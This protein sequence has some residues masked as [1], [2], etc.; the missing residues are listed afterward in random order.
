MW[1]WKLCFYSW[2][3]G[4]S[5]IIVNDVNICVNKVFLC[6]QKNHFDIGKWTGQTLLT[7]QKQHMENAWKEHK[8]PVI[9]D[10]KCHFMDGVL[11]KVDNQKPMWFT[12]IRDPVTRFQSMFHLKR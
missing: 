1:I 12:I 10:R 5:E 9:Y 11:S 7:T 6:L 3:L 4:Q 2:E 8:R